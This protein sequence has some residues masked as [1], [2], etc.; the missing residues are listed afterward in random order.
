MATLLFAEPTST[1]Y[2][3]KK[4]CHKHAI[5]VIARVVDPEQDPDP[6]GS[7]SNDKL[8]PDPHIK[9]INW[10]GSS[11]ICRWQESLLEHFFKVEPLF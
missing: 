2:A 4:I 5:S 1:V 9:V 6:H 10:K 11:S 7:A 3:T 8:D